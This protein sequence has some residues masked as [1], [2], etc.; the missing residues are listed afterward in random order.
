[1][2]NAGLTPE[3]ERALIQVAVW[4]ENGAKHVTVDKT[5]RVLDSFN[6]EYG[7]DKTRE[8]ECGT[9]CCIAGAVV[10]FNG[11][12][13]LD[14][15]GEVHWVYIESAASEFLGMSSRN[16]KA[17]FKPWSLP[18][19]CDMDDEDLEGMFN[20]PAVAAETIRNYLATGE[21]VWDI[22]E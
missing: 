17:L 13:D 3:A 11:L 10:Q 16:V 14:F 15:H 20:D 2:N 9:S 18:E 19:F 21:I 5:G 22:K 7:I 8:P 12:C 6:M 1:M 4:L